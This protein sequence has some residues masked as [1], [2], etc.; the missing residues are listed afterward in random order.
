MKQKG[1]DGLRVPDI[2]CFSFF[3]LLV[4]FLFCLTFPLFFFF[5]FVFF[6][7]KADQS[8]SMFA[9][10]FRGAAQDLSVLTGTTHDFK[11]KPSG[12]VVFMKL[13]LF[14]RWWW[15]SYSEKL[16]VLCSSCC[17]AAVWSY[18]HERLIILGFFRACADLFLGLVCLSQSLKGHTN[19]VECV[20]FNTSEEQV[21][22]GSQSG[23]IRLWDL[24]AAKSKTLCLSVVGE[25]GVILLSKKF[26]TM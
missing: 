2:F 20:Q 17:S 15:G 5:L 8:Q 4:L 10:V 16:N 11:P 3:S 19:P 12:F 6:L 13:K 22:T 24:E 7:Y 14:L 21:V 9:L 25:G 18:K 26:A 23:S 1:K